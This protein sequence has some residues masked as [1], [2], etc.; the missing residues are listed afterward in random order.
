[1]SLILEFWEQSKQI[2]E[3]MASLVY[4]VSSRTAWA[5]Q[6]KPCLGG[7]NKNKTKQKKPLNQPN[8]QNPPNRQYQILLAKI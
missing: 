6:E 8:K 7:K 4:R 1:M 3:F 2:S 5:T